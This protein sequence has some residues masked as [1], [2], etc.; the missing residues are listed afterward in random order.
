MSPGIGVFWARRRYVVSDARAMRDFFARERPEY[1]APGPQP[2]Q[3]ESLLSGPL[4]PTNRPYAIAKI[5]GIELCR[6][7][8]RCTAVWI[9]GVLIRRR[10][11]ASL[12]G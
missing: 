1:Y 4:E 3:E 6:A 2:M 12:W 7:Y 11:R 5:A 9:D 8:H 10:F